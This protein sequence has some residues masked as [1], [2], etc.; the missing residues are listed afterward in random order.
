MPDSG[1]SMHRVTCAIRHD[2]ARDMAAHLAELDI[3]SVL[4]ESGRNVRRR[5]TSRPFGLP[6]FTE[7]LDSGAIDL[8]QFSVPPARSSGIITRLAEA[9]QLNRPG[10]GTIFAQTCQAFVNPP[11]ETGGMPPAETA[12]ERTDLLRDLAMITC[13]TSMNSSAD[14]LARLA[15]ELGTGVPMLT[16]GSGIGLRDRLGLLRI[17]VPPEK[18]LVRLLVPAQDA[19]DVMRLFIEK[20]NLNRPGRGFLFCCP[21]LWGILDTR[22]L[23]GPQQHAATMEQIVAAIDELEKGTAWRR[24]FPDRDQA[25][26]VRLQA[27]QDEISLVCAEETA[28]KYVA[29]AMAAGAASATNAHLH[30]VC[31]DESQGGARERCTIVLRRAVTPQVL[32]ALLEVHRQDD[33]PLEC[34]E[35]QP[36]NL[37]YAYRA[38]A[39]RLFRRP[40]PPPRGPGES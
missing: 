11:E 3:D 28:E 40:S 32:A 38:P 15:L 16:M 23:V 5:R 39:F 27:E 12:A 24:R 17:T 30:R 9:L 8:Y 33:R 19:E 7:R 6:G 29:A 34:L 31:F 18:E 37:A 14:E 36:V 26:N 35:V 21:V 22:L 25:R 4:V 2:R 20:G 1:T 10:H 13:I